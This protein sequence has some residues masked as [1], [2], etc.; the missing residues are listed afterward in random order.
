M[1]GGANLLTI[2]M[3]IFISECREIGQNQ[4][5]MIESTIQLEIL[6]GKGKFEQEPYVGGAGFYKN[7]C[8]NGKLISLSFLTPIWLATPN[9][10][11]IILEFWNTCSHR[12]AN[13][14]QNL[15]LAGQCPMPPLQ[16]SEWFE[17]KVLPSKLQYISAC[18]NIAR[19]LGDCII[20]TNCSKSLL[21]IT[22]A[23]LLQI[24]TKFYYK[25]AV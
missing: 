17:K 8:L 23:K 7:R 14:H 1:A 4:F 18:D 11:N 15:R 21:Q 13:C 19:K 9:F 25:Y 2:R 22:T 12:G 3:W 20:I 10:K 24:T 16:L 5:S 6:T